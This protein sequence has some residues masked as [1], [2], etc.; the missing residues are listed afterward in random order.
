MRGLEAQARCFVTC[1]AVNSLLG[2]WCGAPRACR[3]AKQEWVVGLADRAAALLE[4]MSSVGLCDVVR[5]ATGKRRKVLRRRWLIAKAESCPLR[6]R[7]QP[8]GTLRRR[9]WRLVRP[10]P[11]RTS[12]AL[13]VECARRN[14]SNAGRRPCWWPEVL[15]MSGRER[16]GKS[17][18]A[19]WRGGKILPKG[20][21]GHELDQC[22]RSAQHCCHAKGLCQSLK[23][24]RPR[25]VS[26]V[27]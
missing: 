10:S 26:N 9:L 20:G 13:F 8:L 23:P 24:R 7:W 11:R 27:S 2:C 18:L 21:Q 12:D 22:Q 17:A 4:Q 15:T 25:V 5:Q 3:K 19:S 6:A 14:S 1:F 16:C